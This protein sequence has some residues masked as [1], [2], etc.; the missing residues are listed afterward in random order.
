MGAKFS[1]AGEIP[2]V[3]GRSAGE[4]CWK[5]LKRASIILYLPPI[6]TD[7]NI[8][9]VINDFEYTF[10]LQLGVCNENNEHRQLILTSIYGAASDIA[11]WTLSF[12]FVHGKAG[13]EERNALVFASLTTLNPT[14]V[15]VV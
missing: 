5:N 13:F 2:Y 10:Y 11:R 9:C 7:D 12:L 1:M 8:F 15:F 14:Q 4:S 6:C 3:Q